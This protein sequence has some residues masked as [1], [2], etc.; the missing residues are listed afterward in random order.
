MPTERVSDPFGLSESDFSM[1]PGADDN[2]VDNPQSK[3]MVR[4]I[5]GENVGHAM[6]LHSA[7]Q[8]ELPE[9]RAD[10]AVGGSI[11]TDFM[12][13]AVMQIPAGVYQAGLETGRFVG[14]GIDWL[15]QHFDTAKKVDSFIDSAPSMPD[16][17]AASGPVGG[18][19]RTLSTFVSAAV[20][21]ASKLKAAHWAVRGFGS[22]AVAGATG[23]PADWE[24]TATLIR[25]VAAGNERME[26]AF[27]ALP[28]PIQNLLTALPNMD[29]RHPFIQRLQT[30]GVEGAFGV[31]FDALMTAARV[32]KASREAKQVLQLDR[33]LAA[34]KARVRGDFDLEVKVSDDPDVVEFRKLHDNLTKALINK[35]PQQI[36]QAEKRIQNFVEANPQVASIAGDSPHLVASMG[37]GVLSK[38]GV[39]A[40]KP[41]AFA[42][43]G[44]KGIF[45]GSEQFIDP[46]K[47]ADPD[48]SKFILA[49]VNYSAELRDNIAKMVAKILTEVKH[50]VPGRP[51]KR[52]EAV[53]EFESAMSRLGEDTHSVLTGAVIRGPKKAEDAFALEVIR[54]AHGMKTW[55]LMKQTLAG[56]MSA[57][58]MLPKQMAIGAEIEAIARSVKSPLNKE[59]LKQIDQSIYLGFDP[60]YA[61]DNL[62]HVSG[63]GFGK[64]FNEEATNMMIRHSE[65]VRDFDGIDLALRLNMIRS[66]EAYKQMMRQ[67]GRPGMFDAFLEYFYN[68]ILSGMDTITGNFVSSHAFAIYQ[69][70]VRAMAGMVGVVDSA[71]V[72]KTTSDIKAGEF[73]AMTYGYTRGMVDQ[74]LPFARNLGRVAT[75]RKPVSESGLQKFEAFDREAFGAEGLK[76]AIL[77]ADKIMDN[78][79]R[80]ALSIKTPLE[81][82]TNSLGRILRTVQNLFI[83]GDEMN[84]GV[85]WSMSAHAQAYR[86]IVNS[87]KSPLGMTKEFRDKVLHTSKKSGEAVDLG[88]QIAFVDEVEASAGFRD[89]V[90]NYPAMRVLFPFVR[91][92]ASI[93]SAFVN[94]T[95]FATLSPRFWKALNAGGGERQ[96]ALSKLIVGS[97]LSYGIYEGWAAGRLTGSGPADGASRGMMSRMGWQP[98]SILVGGDSWFAS[99][100]DFERSME[101][102]VERVI[103]GDTIDV[104]DADGEVHRVRLKGLDAAELGTFEGISAKEAM[105]S[106]LAD[107]P[108]VTINWSKMAAKKSGKNWGDRLLGK[109]YLNGMDIG[110]TM[111][112]QGAGQ[113]RPEPPKYISIRAFEPFA[114]HMETFVNSFELLSKMDDD[115]ERSDSLFRSVY[116]DVA[117]NLLNKQYT[118]G[119]MTILDVVNGGRGS[120]KL[121]G[122]L[123]GT[124][125]PA[126]TADTAKHLD[127]THRDFRT[128]DPNLTPEHAALV[129]MMSGAVS[130]M[131]WLSKHLI[132]DYDG[133]GHVGVKMPSWGSSFFN[134]IPE[135]AQIDNPVWKSFIV[136]NYFPKKLRPS[137]RGADL[138]LEEYAEYQKLLGTVKIGGRNI[139]EEY[140]E[141]VSKFD[142]RYDTVGPDGIQRDLLQSVRT[143]YQME[144][145]FELINKYPEIEDRIDSALDLS[146]EP[147]DKSI[148][149]EQ[150]NVGDRSMES[151]FKGMGQ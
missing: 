36:G 3:A 89:F 126:I 87:G 39:A 57:A 91:S 52:D 70:P 17:P 85:A 51:M 30:G 142:S 148:P 62:D 43:L 130:R 29:E 35:N 26:K 133:L 71:I 1:P 22:A 67:A 128:I 151:L 118:K 15:G 27:S 55:Q 72:G 53:Q 64:N 49:D 135:S 28:K 98:N 102:T 40:L 58:R 103:D 47:L 139:M 34:E 73:L 113:F 74:F 50:K 97:G 82:F 124:L 84:R 132:P 2:I 4:G 65:M 86:S 31:P 93:F 95:P 46:L 108:Q 131:P 69:I 112:S 145:E 144:A 14:D 12:S 81:F 134:I 115:P 105:Q 110:E 80:G 120:D 76:P 7:P 77:A 79:T 83:T 122:R 23:F 119:L 138:S 20:L 32:W 116:E 101:G 143:S 38:W 96:L 137:I 11:Y 37:K 16:W 19:L 41:T 13:S 109:V 141:T 42:Q 9:E 78:A 100:F 44:K 149:F 54:S 92:Q 117:S 99:M 121:P 56:D 48:L 125:V 136:N 140:R 45:E 129:K 33:S 21:P 10:T 6:E 60:K 104:K 61:R 8:F 147:L 114:T 111:I 24:N 5:N 59:M 146:L 127:P 66:P 90:D 18:V 88:N 107:N 106:I 25:D 94:N 75:A 63:F 150:M 123:M 68:A